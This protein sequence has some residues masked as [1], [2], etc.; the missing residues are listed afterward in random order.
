MIKMCIVQ[1]M[2]AS[3][4]ETFCLQLNGNMDVTN[5]CLQMD[6]QDLRIIYV[7]VIVQEVSG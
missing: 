5:V 2:R 1:W 7:Q 4:D 6:V 3:I